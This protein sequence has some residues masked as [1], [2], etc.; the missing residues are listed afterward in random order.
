MKYLDSCAHIINDKETFEFYINIFL[1]E[2][3]TTFYIFNKC[4]TQIYSFIMKNIS[5]IVLKKK[6]LLFFNIS[7]ILIHMKNITSHKIKNNQLCIFILFF[8]L[9]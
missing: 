6:S 4:K 5:I 2:Q 3:T 9:I 8:I 1:N 7:F